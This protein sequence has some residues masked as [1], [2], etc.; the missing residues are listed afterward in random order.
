MV[1]SVT[2]V[3]KHSSGLNF[4]FVRSVRQHFTI[5]YMQESIKKK[6]TRKSK[7]ECEKQAS[8]HL[9]CLRV[10]GDSGFR[11]RILSLTAARSKAP[12]PGQAVH[13]PTEEKVKVRQ[14]L[15]KTGHPSLPPFLV[16]RRLGGEG[17]T[18]GGGGGGTP[19]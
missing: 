5:R 9:N 3:C 17:C 18:G 8:D 1:I 4:L 14:T 6:N 19:G 16:D 13:S 11:R 10:C 15:A 2:E 7:C 12:R